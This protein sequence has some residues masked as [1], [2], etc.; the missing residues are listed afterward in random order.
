[1]P[2]A[3]EAAVA[4]G[5]VFLFGFSTPLDK[6]KVTALLRMQDQGVGVRRREGFGRVVVAS[7]FHWEVKGQ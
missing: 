2:R 6:Q 5:S 3:D 7:P 1:M 4:M